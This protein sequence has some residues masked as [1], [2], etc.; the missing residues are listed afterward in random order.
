MDSGFDSAPTLTPPT[1]NP[2][3]LAEERANEQEELEY[4]KL[5]RE[6]I[7]ENAAKEAECGIYAAVD[8]PDGTFYHFLCIDSLNPSVPATPNLHFSVFV[9]ILR[10]TLR[11]RFLSKIEAGI[12]VKL[13]RN[14]KNKKKSKYRNMLTNILLVK[15]AEYEMKPFLYHKLTLN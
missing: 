6:N 4:A 3:F 5:R 13:D 12:F 7:Y 8:I 15:N 2:Q 1:P 11:S 14:N 10:E 9:E